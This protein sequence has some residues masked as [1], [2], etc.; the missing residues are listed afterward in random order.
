MVV[1]LSVMVETD[2]VRYLERATIAR[3]RGMNVVPYRRG[4]H[5]SSVGPSCVRDLHRAA[6][7]AD[8]GVE[9]VTDVDT[10]ERRRTGRPVE[11][12]EADD[13]GFE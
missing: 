4:R 10:G 11:G 12:G 3:M 5:A 13:R 6:H 8:L 2:P 1:G 7:V 9:V